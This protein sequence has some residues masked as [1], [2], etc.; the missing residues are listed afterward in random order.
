MSRSPS[1]SVSNKATSAKN[2]IRNGDFETGR[3]APWE[4]VEGKMVVEEFNGSHQAKI[5]KAETNSHQIKNLVDLEAGHYEFGIT[6]TSPNAGEPTQ[7][8]SKPSETVA[9]WY[10]MFQHEGVIYIENQYS[11][12][13]GPEPFTYTNPFD[14]PEGVKQLSVHVII[15]NNPKAPGP[16]YVDNVSITKID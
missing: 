2:Y 16:T 3:L 10:C 12:F 4:L 11:L 15:I 9:I 8:A 14:I 1:T 5:A 7:T 6:V 13:L